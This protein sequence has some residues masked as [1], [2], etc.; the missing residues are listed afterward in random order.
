MD[1]STILDNIINENLEEDATLFIL[2]SNGEKEEE[3]ISIFKKNTKY[4]NKTKI[5]LS[6]NK[7]N[8]EI[9]M[10]FSTLKDIHL[11]PNDI[12]IKIINTQ[13]QKEE[14]AD[15]WKD[16]PYKD[17]VKLQSNNVGIVGEN[18]IQNICDICQ[19]DAHVDGSKTKGGGIGDGLIL[20]KSI[21]I[22]TSHRGCNTPIFQ[23][24]LGENP[25]KSEFMVFIDVAPECIYL[26]IFKNF[27]EEFYKSGIKCFPY[28]PT[29]SI[30]W[31][32]GSGAFKL[33]TTVKINKENIIKGNTFCIDSNVDLNKLKTFLLLKIE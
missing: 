5:K 30:T 4:H 24:E 9:I 31:R 13:K 27:D 20:K 3:E 29:K 23:H 25:W 6:S 26:T 12:F 19:I 2:R 28:F 22:K 18:F 16:S 17:L 33:D 1:K 10:P 15:I 11:L 21:E 32:K 7:I 8:S 14:N